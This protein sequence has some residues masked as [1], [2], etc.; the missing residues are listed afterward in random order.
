MIDEK[1]LK[2]VME[3]TRKEL[4]KQLTSAIY[5]NGYPMKGVAHATIESLPALIRYDQYQKWLHQKYTSR[6]I[7]IDDK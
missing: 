2:Q 1:E 7:D 5:D 6:N 4:R 3:Y